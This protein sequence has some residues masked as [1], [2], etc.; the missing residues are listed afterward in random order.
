MW[1]KNHFSEEKKR[2]LNI[3]IWLSSL[4][5]A[6]FFS[7]SSCLREV[8]DQFVLIMNQFLN[9]ELFWKYFT[10]ISLNSLDLR[11]KTMNLWLWYA[12]K[13]LYTIRRSSCSWMSRMR[14]NE[15]WFQG[16]IEFCLALCDNIAERL[17]A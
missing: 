1:I 11:D 7:T 6:W 14:R 15:N 16:S 12:K 8:D 17:Q 13:I 2:Y 10:I 5:W 3:C 9:S 4:K